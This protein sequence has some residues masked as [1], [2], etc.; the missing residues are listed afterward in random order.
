MSETDDYGRQEN[1]DQEPTAKFDRSDLVRGWREYD[2]IYH[3][4]FACMR[5]NTGYP[6]GFAYNMVPQAHLLHL[7]LG[8]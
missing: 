6:K 8:F 5:G 3:A 2:S 4:V 1:S 7:R